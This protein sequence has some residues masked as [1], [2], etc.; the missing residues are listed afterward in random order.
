PYKV[1]VYNEEA[2]IE[3]SAIVNSHNWITL[4]VNNIEYVST[5]DTDPESIQ[6]TADS[7]A[8]DY[9]L[10]I[11]TI[12]IMVPLNF[13]VQIRDLVTIFNENLGVSNRGIIIKITENLGASLTST[14]TLAVI[15]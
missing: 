7:I 2:G 11:F 12:D 6:D 9:S 13:Y 8:E 4:D 3:K 10:K 5:D 14:L 1:V 15:E